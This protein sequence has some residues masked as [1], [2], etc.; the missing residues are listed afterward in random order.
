[1]CAICVLSESRQTEV[2]EREPIGL[3]TVHQ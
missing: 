3:F 2:K 1:V